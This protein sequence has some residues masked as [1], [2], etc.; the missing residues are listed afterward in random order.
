VGVIA[1]A[2]SLE[3]SLPPNTAIDNAAFL[4][5]GSERE[6]P[7]PLPLRTVASIVN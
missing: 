6:A 4:M 2:T 3:R 7:S 1:T 5:A